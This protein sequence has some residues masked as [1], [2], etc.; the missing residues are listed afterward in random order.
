MVNISITIYFMQISAMVFQ[1][2]EIYYTIPL[3]VEHLAGLNSHF[4]LCVHDNKKTDKNYF[5]GKK[6][7]RKK[8]WSTDK[9]SEF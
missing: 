1:F 8:C 5:L 3:S 9:K 6:K 7:Q 2:Y 4:S